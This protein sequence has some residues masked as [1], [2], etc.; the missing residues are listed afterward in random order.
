MR[1]QT[2]N[3]TYNIAGNL[4]PVTQITSIGL[5]GRQEKM[6]L[7]EGMFQLD[8]KIEPSTLMYLTKLGPFNATVV[9]LTLCRLIVLSLKKELNNP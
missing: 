5:R 7:N 8:L 4:L 3:P 9:L 2:D 6:N 1:V